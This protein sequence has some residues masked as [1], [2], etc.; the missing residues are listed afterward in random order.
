MLRRIAVS[1]VHSCSG[2]YGQLQRSVF[3]VLF[4]LCHM[5]YALPLALRSQ[6]ILFEV[7]STLHWLRYINTF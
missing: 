3:L 1:E 6:C 4:P 7:R 2:L 5:F